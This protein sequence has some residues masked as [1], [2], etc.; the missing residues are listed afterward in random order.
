MRNTVSGTASDE[1]FSTARRNIAQMLF[2]AVGMQ[3]LVYF[4]SLD[5]LENLPQKLLDVFAKSNRDSGA[6]RRI[7]HLAVKLDQASAIRGMNIKSLFT[8]EVTAPF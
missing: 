8:E 5:S 6:L 2:T 4:T 7:L 1:F 3:K